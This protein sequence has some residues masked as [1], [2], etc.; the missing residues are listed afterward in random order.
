MQKNMTETL[1][2]LKK[3]Q[4]VLAEKYD[5]ELGACKMRIFRARQKLSE[6]LKSLK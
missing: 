5:L 3:L 4:D 2:S 6:Q 1:E